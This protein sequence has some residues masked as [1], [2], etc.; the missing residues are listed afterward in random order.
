MILMT[1][2]DKMNQVLEVMRKDGMKPQDIQKF[3]VTLNNMLA[4]QVYHRMMT[5]L[6]EDD[7]SAIETPLDRARV[8]LEVGPYIVL[9]SVMAKRRFFFEKNA[10]AA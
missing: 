5:T 6:S 7:L 4:E 10:V 8:L 3:I 2:Q 1:N 9:R